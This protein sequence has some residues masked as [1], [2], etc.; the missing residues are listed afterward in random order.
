MTIFKLYEGWQVFLKAIQRN[1]KEILCLAVFSKV[2][3]NFQ[4]L[5]IG[6]DIILKSKYPELH[7]EMMDSRIY[8][9]VPLAQLILEHMGLP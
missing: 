8:I 1:F 5:H 4:L 6:I 7:G 2:V 3:S 9:N